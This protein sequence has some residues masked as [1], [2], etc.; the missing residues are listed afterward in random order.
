MIDSNKSIESNGCCLSQIEINTIA[1]SF[2]SATTKLF[3]LHRYMLKNTNNSEF[4]NK[5]SLNTQS[6]IY[7][8]FNFYLSNI[9]M[10]I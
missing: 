10:I 4:I 3:E 7:H 8:E 6:I 1:S 2:G 5:V 9:K